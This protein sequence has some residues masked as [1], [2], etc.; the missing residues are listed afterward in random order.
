MIVC[1]RILFTRFPYESAYGGAEVQTLA[2]MQGL[3]ARGHAVAFLGSCEV[4][5]ELCKKAN[6]PHAELDIGKPPV[7]KWMALSFPFRKQEMFSKLR[8]ALDGFHELDAV[9]M[10]S[11]SEKILL[12]DDLTSQGIRT[13]WIEHDRPG[14]WLS[15]NPWLKSL[16]SSAERATTITVSEQ[17][18]RWYIDAGWPEQ[19]L[20]AVPNGVPTTQRAARKKRTA[21]DPLHVGTMC[22]L[23]E[24][25]GV[26]VLLRA[27]AKDPNMHVTIVGRGKEKQH[28]LRLIE[29]LDI[30]ERAVIVDWIEERMSFLSS[31]DAFVLPSRMH[32]PFG[33]AASEA[34]MAGVPTIVTSVC[35]IADYLQAGD[36]AL[37]VEPDSVSSLTE[38]LQQ[39]RDPDFAEILAESGKQHAEDVFSLDAMVERYENILTQE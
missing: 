20:V 37:V 27:V 5:L 8:H 26:D 3:I 34:M 11:L 28:L 33:I 19:R 1:M 7:S 15:Q 35:G 23:S 2:L 29:D 30:Q 16:L 24:D 4:L 17:G 25:K 14:R 6:I 9:C 10:L 39:L 32:D 21:E 36:H 31:I 13:L 22:R 38:A 12:T 18:K